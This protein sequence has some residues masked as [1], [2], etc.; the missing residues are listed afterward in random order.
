MKA[1]ILDFLLLNILLL[2][3]EL[4]TLWTKL[5][6]EY[7]STVCRTDGVGV[8]VAKFNKLIAMMSCAKAM[9]VAVLIISLNE[10]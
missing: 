1:L 2:R 6:G 4:V 3:T 5:V 9:C 7:F 10:R 8:G